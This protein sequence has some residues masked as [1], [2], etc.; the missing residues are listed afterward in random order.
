VDD[1][2][3]E[4]GVGE[5]VLLRDAEVG[6]Q[7][8]GVA[9]GDQRGDGDEAAIPG[10]KFLAFPDV[11]EQHVISQGHELGCEVADDLLSASLGSSSG[12]VSPF[13]Q[14]EQR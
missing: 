11:A 12:M 4:L 14:G 1:R 10:R 3:L 8:F 13:G 5:A 6:S 7:L 2:F 9:A